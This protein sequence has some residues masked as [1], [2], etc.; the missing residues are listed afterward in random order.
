MQFQ[1]ILVPLAAIGALIASYQMDRRSLG[2]IWLGD[3]GFAAFQPFDANPQ[4][5]G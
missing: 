5:C 4:T 3:M 2:G 1:K